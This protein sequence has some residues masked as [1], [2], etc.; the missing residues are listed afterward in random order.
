MESLF[1][2]SLVFLGT[3]LGISSTLLR[4]RLVSVLGERGYQG[5]YSLI[6]LAALSYFIWLYT[7]LPRFDYLWMPS[8]ERYTAAK[9]V[10]PLSLILVVGGFLVKNP[11]AV[12]MERLLDDGK[13]AELARGVTRITRHPF[14]WG[15]V[16]WS[17]AHLLANGDRVSVLFFATFGILSGLG[18]VLI[19]R[20]KA[21]SLGARWQPYAAVTSNLPFGAIVSGRNR[22]VL[23]E[24]WPPV[25]AG[26]AV[27]GLV[28][29]G[30]QW[31]S[32]VR[33]I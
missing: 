18:T 27:Y 19:D 10:M 24:L 16:V 23:G 13:G 3:H 28:F 5:I 33:L 14:Q 2:A 32:G 6:A 12:G 29:W 15:V 22:L 7:E 17:I 31:V 21:A 11:T 8:P 9:L 26:L 4:A 30:H 20:K 25:L 1:I